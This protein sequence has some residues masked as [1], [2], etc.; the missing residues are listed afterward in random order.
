MPFIFGEAKLIQGNCFDWLQQIDDNSVHALVTDPPYGLEE[1]TVKEQSKLRAGRGGVWRLPPQYDGNKR[2]SVP[3]CTVLNEKQ[4][5]TLHDFC[6]TCARYLIPKLR[7][8]ANVIIASHSLLAHIVSSA[9][10]SVGLE[11]RGEIIRLV[12]TLRGGDRPKGTHQEFRNVTVMPRSM[13]EPWISL[14]KPLDDTVQNNLRRC[15]TGGFRRLFDEAPF[16]DVIRSAPTKKRERG[17]A[18]HPSL[19]PQV[20]LCNLVRAVLPLGEGTVVDT[21]AGSVLTLAAAEA[22]GYRSTGVETDLVYFD[23]ATYAMEKL[24]GLQTAADP[25][26]YDQSAR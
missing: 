21:F 22:I 5:Q 3:R 16:G 6:F 4:L 25:S 12:T 17:I 19:K 1:Y 15:G 9:A 7:P 26:L 24:A 8:G 18:P 20:F 11:K 14:R 10:T 23:M 13:W 2:N